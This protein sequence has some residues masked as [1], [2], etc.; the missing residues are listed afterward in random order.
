MTITEEAVRQ[1][2]SAVQDPDLGRDI[3]TLG[4]VKDVVIEGG[5]VGFTVELTTP[6]CPVKEQL[7]A[8][9]EEVVR[10]INGV[11]EVEVTMTARVRERKSQN[12]DLIPGV[13]QVIAIASGKGGV[14]KSTATVNLA[15]ALAKTG[16]KVGVMDA[17]VYGPSIPLMLGCHGEHPYTRDQKIVPIERFGLKVMSLGFLLEEGQAVLWR[18]PMVASTVKQLLGDVDWGELDYLLVDLPPGTGDA[19]MSL[20]QLV[21]LT[22]VVLVTTPHNVASNIAGKAALLFKRLNAP[23]LGVMENM[24]VFV[25]PGC[26]QEE[27]I[28]SGQSGE[29]LA[30]N[31]KVPYLGTVPLDPKVSHSADQGLPS[32]VAFPDS[33]QANAFMGIARVLAAQASVLAMSRTDLHR[34]AGEKRPQFSPVT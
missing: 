31:L 9:C 14:G 21:P 27:R 19:P 20:A 18:G 32:V 16:A 26:G 24:A 13:K 8:E 7:Q 2:L 30:A 1:A 5:K 23:I 3:V 33:A 28:F 10:A 17:D 34:L 25:C 29:E 22:G 15:V 4:F 6:A 11:T 12:E